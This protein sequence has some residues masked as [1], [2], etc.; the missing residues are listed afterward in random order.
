MDFNSLKKKI[1]IDSDIIPPLGQFTKKNTTLGHPY[2]NP[3][4]QCENI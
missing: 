2:K 4:N 1:G 3:L